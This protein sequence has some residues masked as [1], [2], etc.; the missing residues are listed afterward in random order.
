MDQNRFLVTMQFNEEDLLPIFLRHYSQYFKPENI[1]ILDHGSSKNLIPSGFNRIYIPR[2]KKF[3]EMDRNALVKNICNGLLGY[4]DYGMYADC[5]E[6]IN[7]ENVDNSIFQNSSVLYVAG[8][9]C[10]KLKIDGENRL[11][12]LPTPSE[13]KPLIFNKLPSWG[14]GFHN[15][16]VEN[17][18]EELTI[19]MIHIR[20]LDRQIAE[21][22]A[23]QKMQMQSDMLDKERE[24]G[25][26][27]HWSRAKED[28][29]TFFNHITYLAGE[30]KV[31]DKFS[32]LKR[33]ELFEQV[34][35]KK[36]LY[37]APKFGY[38]FKGG[39][40]EQSHLYDLTD[41]FPLMSQNYPELT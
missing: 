7:L 25:I 8:F 20:F 15:C 27:D 39:Y 23:L 35:M 31:F 22:K 6:L 1:Y 18:L 36:T 28:V 38:V 12:G 13:C 29:L 37:T 11:I 26:N 40:I 34:V 2:E 3:S 33:D 9:E 10:T 32:P 30:K 16:Q 41:L 17:P 21:K 5:D 14:L 4:Y 19:P 24:I